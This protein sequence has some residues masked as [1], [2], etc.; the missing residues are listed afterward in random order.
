MKKILFLGISVL[1][2]AGNIPDCLSC[3]DI[4]YLTPKEIKAKLHHFKQGE[5]NPMMVNIAKNLS[6][7]DIEKI[8]NQ[9]GKK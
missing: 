4:S 3:H 7:K 1:A 8:A 6:E 5:G 2:F 9:Y